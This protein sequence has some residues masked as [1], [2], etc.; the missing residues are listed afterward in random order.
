MEQELNLKG[1]EV[2][3]TSPLRK[4]SPNDFLL[5]KEKE[6]GKQISKRF[7]EYFLR[8][9]DAISN[10]SYEQVWESVFGRSRS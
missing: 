8:E 2:K 7:R 6:T 4:E 1:K 9:L 5:K 3:I 10:R